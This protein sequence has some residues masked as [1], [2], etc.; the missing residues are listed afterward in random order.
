MS[1]RSTKR[2]RSNTPTSK[3]TLEDLEKEAKEFRK[4]TRV[5]AKIPSDNEKPLTARQHLAG[6]V[7]S[8]LLARSQGLVN[9]SDLRREAYDW[10]DRMLE[11]E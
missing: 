7:L 2:T 6:L 10:A 11:D 1:G 4:N 8:G 5:V 3:A 9:A